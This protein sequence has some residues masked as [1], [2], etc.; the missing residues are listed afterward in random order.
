[1]EEDQ[2]AESS[3]HIVYGDIKTALK[4]SYTFQSFL[5]QRKYAAGVTP[6]R[7]GILPYMNVLP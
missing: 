4:C 1:M 2:C 7:Y 6:F 5:Y 3:V